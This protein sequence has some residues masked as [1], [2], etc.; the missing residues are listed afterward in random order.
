[1]IFLFYQN[2]LKKKLF[3]IF[4]NVD[5]SINGNFDQ[6]NANILNRRTIMIDKEIESKVRDIQAQL[7]LNTSTNWSFST[8]ANLLMLSGISN[9]EKLT[10]EEVNLLKS[11][12][13]GES[14]SLKKK[15]IKKILANFSS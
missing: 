4:G 3:P 9:S 11:F 8:V 7:I 15:N 12:V 14:I 6:G 13:A 5:Q 2:F 10:R 1:M